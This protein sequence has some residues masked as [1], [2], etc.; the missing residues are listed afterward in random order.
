MIF[1]LKLE[2]GSK[3]ARDA[4]DVAALLVEAAARVSLKVGEDGE[5]GLLRDDDGNRIGRWDFSDT[6]PAEFVVGEED[7]TGQSFGCVKN[8]SYYDSDGDVV[9]TCSRERDHKGIHAA[10]NGRT[11]AAVWADEDYDA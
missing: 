8:D 2:M 1:K 4:D 5:F 9:Y 3:G 7:T 10:G 6:D 11:I